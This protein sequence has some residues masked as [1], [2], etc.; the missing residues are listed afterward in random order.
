MP[1]IVMAG[2]RESGK[3]TILAL[4]YAAQVR[5]GSAT[6]DRFR[7]HASFES[8]DE[9][10]NVFQQLMSGSFPDAAAKEGV[11]GLA[12]HLSYRRPLGILSRLRSQEFHPDASAALQLILLRNLVEEVARYRA[13]R[14]FTHV[15]LRDVL[16][17]DG[18][19]IVV[20]SRR[21]VIAAEDQER[22]AMQE[23]DATVESL[24]AAVAAS[25]AQSGRS[26]LHPMVIFS[27]FDA[28]EDR[29]LRAAGV[30]GTPPDIRKKGARTHYAEALLDHNLPRT[31]AKIRSRES[32][33]LQLA[34]PSYFFSW[35]RTEAARAGGRE[36]VRLRPGEGAGWEPDYSVDEYLAL[37]ECLWKIAMDAKP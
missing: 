33:A 23:Y 36:R 2:D 8:L 22:G 15:P 1:R 18:L 24:L 20:D 37:L 14:S 10:S 29:A 34:R 16:E 19:G 25:R 6:T 11:R 12:F 4:L 30:E 21:L 32:G 7:F 27:K 3:T 31:M 17:C 5:S 13:G 26:W 9:I 28:V 35:V